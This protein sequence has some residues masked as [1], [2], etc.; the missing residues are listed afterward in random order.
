[1]PTAT[2]P[3]TTPTRRSA[4]GFTLAAL[5]AGLTVPVLASAAKPDADAEL[6]NAYDRLVEVETELW[7]LPLHDEYAPDFGPNHTRYRQL[8]DEQDRLI[9]LAGECQSAV[10][11]A[12]M[13]ALARAAMTWTARDHEGNAV[14]NDFGEEMMLK[15]AES[16]AAGFVWPP[17]PGSCSTA[18]WAP[19]SSA[20]EIA[21][22]RAAWDAK[23]AA[24]DAKV[25][26]QQEARAAEALRSV[27]PALMTDDKLRERLEGA[28]NIG[29]VSDQIIREYTAEMARRGP[30]A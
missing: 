2:Q 30:A 11:A 18:H 17:R 1:M 28:Q 21:E 3:H 29:A 25:Q 8:L 19:P 7:L 9:D 4:I 27:T 23:T 12:G 10:N 26:A 16:V 14:C 22:H 13:V 5:T 24:V 20:R 15:L 6:I